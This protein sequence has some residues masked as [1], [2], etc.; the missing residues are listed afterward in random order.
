MVQENGVPYILLLLVN[1]SNLEPDVLFSQRS[2]R[3]RNNV[4]EALGRKSV[5]VARVST[6]TNVNY[7]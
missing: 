2:R 1:M 7:L 4:L 6:E 5:S 3:V